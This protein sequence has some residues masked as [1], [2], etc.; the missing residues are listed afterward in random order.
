MKRLKELTSDMSF[1]NDD[2]L[3]PTVSNA[4]K[5][6]GFHDTKIN[7]QVSLLHATF[8]KLSD[9]QIWKNF[10]LGDESAFTY[11]YYQ[12]FAVL[13]RYGSQFLGA[14]SQVKDHIHDLFIELSD[15]RA[16]LSDTTSIK[17]YLMRSL[18]NRILA[19]KKRSNK[20]A[21][22]ED[23][24]KGFSFEI[25]FSIEHTIIDKQA[26]EERNQKL[27]KA[28]KTLTKRQR[29]LIFYYYFEEL[30]IEEIMVLMDFSNEK[31]LQNLLYKSIHTLRNHFGTAISLLLISLLSF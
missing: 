8:E 16:R 30:K 6:V 4:E 14:H 15:R 18:K 19:D 25:S 7:H 28:I 17:F 31:S 5:K 13:C 2:L 20:L 10:K 29:E 1:S 3:H 21:S 9:E 26:T 24:E 11:I 27:N 23:Q 12:Y 22:E